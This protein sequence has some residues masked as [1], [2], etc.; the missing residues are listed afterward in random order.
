MPVLPSSTGASANASRQKCSAMSEL[1]TANKLSL[2]WGDNWKPSLG[3]DLDAGISSTWSALLGLPRSP[4]CARTECTIGL[5]PFQSHHPPQ[6]RPPARLLCRNVP[7]RAL[8][9]PDP[10]QKDR[11]PALRAHRHLQEAR[12]NRQGRT[13]RSSRGGSAHPISGLP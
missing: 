2:H 9:Y 4:D 3:G 6:K 11:L 5:D 7:D 13:R 1:N 8:E 12:R 10:R